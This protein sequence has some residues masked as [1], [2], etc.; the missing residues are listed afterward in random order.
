MAVQAGVHAQSTKPDA[1]RRRDWLPYMLALPIIIYEG[2][3]ILIP[4]VQ[5]FVSSFTSDVFG[6]G[7]V[8]W[9]GLANYSRMFNDAKFWNSLKVTLIFM[10][11][12]VVF[13]VG[14]GLIAGIL[15][16]QRFRGRSV[17]RAIM[18]LPWAFPGFAHCSCVLLDFEPQL[19]DHQCCSTSVPALA[20]AES[21][22]AERY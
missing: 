8:K 16:N 2:I 10:G 22:M 18:T 19:W 13:A 1:G 15:M 7:T 20:G 14:I 12:T 3:F 4:I 21:Q 11:G 9:V 6:I 5:Q 17:A